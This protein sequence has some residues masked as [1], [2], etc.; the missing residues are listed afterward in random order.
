[1]EIKKILHRKEMKLITLLLTSLLIASASAAM[2]FSLTMTSTIQVYKAQVYFVKGSDNGQEGLVVTLDGT[3]TTASLSGLRAYANATFTYTDPVRV[4]NNGSV[5]AQLRLVPEVNP[6]ANPEDFEY[7]KFLLNATTSG[8]RKWLNYTSNGV[9][10]TNP[11]GST[12]WTTTGILATNEWPIV[13]MT[14]ANATAVAGQ[15]VTI[16]IKVDVD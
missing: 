4:R 12:S 1:M 3:N 8:D 11:S 13:V 2:Y 7:V 16:S 14:K 5:T 15:T 10:W 6:S 9:S